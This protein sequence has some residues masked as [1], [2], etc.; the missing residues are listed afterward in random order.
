MMNYM[1]SMFIDNELSIDDKIEFVEKVHEDKMFKN[2]SIDLLHQEK[3]IRSEVVSH[4]PQ[5]EFKM[6]RRFV[7][8][9]LRPVGLF[10]SA[11][12]IAIVIVSLF[13]HPQV[14]A[15]I[16]NRF[17]IYQ[18]NVIQAEIAGDFT[19]WRK[20]PMRRIGSS[21]YWE[22]T[23]NIPKGEHR[24]TYILDGDQGFADPTMLTREKDDFGGYNSIISVEVTT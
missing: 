15:S 21:G 8:P 24:F 4:V 23:I 19:E 11:L 17:V 1:I 3:F 2:E 18:P 14:R 5:V 22:I 12:A 9:L 6:K 16:P 13:A 20:V 7:F 10:A